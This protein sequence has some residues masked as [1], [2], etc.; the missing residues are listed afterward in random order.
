MNNV[1]V[2]SDTH[3]G[4]ANILNFKGLDDKPLR[5]FDDVHH[6]DE[7][8][9]EKWNSIVTPQDHVYH[10]GDVIVKGKDCGKLLKRL[11]GHKRLVLG[12]HDFPKMSEYTPYFEKI[13][14]SRLL[15]QLLMTHIPVHPLSLGKAIA[16]IHGHVHSNVPDDHFG[17]QYINVSVEVVDYTP[18]ALEDL[19]KLALKRLKQ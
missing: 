7:F 11:N 17:K 15:D 13:Y 14:G 1:F 19:K 12:N 8:M 4:H 5:V 16:N 9:I 2:I 6:M 10:L 18:V 3:F